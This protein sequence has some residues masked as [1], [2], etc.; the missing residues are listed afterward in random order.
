M[1]QTLLSGLTR[2][3]VTRTRLVLM[4]GVLVALKAIDGFWTLW[5]TNHGYME[6]N[7]IMVPIAHTWWG[8]VATT[9]PLVVFGVLVVWIT[10]WLPQTAKAVSRGLVAACALMVVVLAANLIAVVG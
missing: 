10:G 3:T 4:F 9:L 7:P 8:P 1:R 6:L 2:S 5:A